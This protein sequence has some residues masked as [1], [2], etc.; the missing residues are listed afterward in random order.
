MYTSTEP[1]LMC[2]GAIYLSGIGRVVY[3]LAAKDLASLPGASD[4]V[5][6]VPTPMAEAL[7][8]GDG[9]PEIR[10]QPMGPA[11]LEPHIDY[12]KGQSR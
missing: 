5:R 10:H 7:A 3:A 9:R 1:C 11:A 6:M 2:A 8:G 12:W 4:R